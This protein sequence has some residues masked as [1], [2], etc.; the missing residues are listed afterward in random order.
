M[1]LS[2]RVDLS[3]LIDTLTIFE[4]LY[5][6]DENGAQGKE[7]K[8]DSGFFHAVTMARPADMR[9]SWF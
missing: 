7:H 9:Q 1:P 8:G 5:S 2:L 4:Q 3:E 6:A